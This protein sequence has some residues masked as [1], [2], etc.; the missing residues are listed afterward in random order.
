MDY[1][2]GEIK[3]FTYN[4]IPSGWLSCSGQTLNANQQNLVPLY[5]LIGNIYGGKAPQTFNLPNLNGTVIVGS[6]QAATGTYYQL[7]AAGGSEIVLLTQQNMPAHNHSVAATNSYN[8]YL[9]SS[10]FL[11]NPNVVGSSPQRTN[12]S[13]A[14]LYAAYNPNGITN[15]PVDTVTNAGDDKAHENRQPFMSLVYCIAINGTYPQRP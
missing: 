14:N 15:L 1:Y 10:N 6:G 5:S 7:G 4:S 8:A 9:P 2:I 3:L 13:T 12:A 11:G